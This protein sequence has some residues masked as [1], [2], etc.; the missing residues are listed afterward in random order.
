[1]G[2]PPLFCLDLLDWKRMRCTR[3]QPSGFQI[4]IQAVVPVIFRCRQARGLPPTPGV[5][6]QN[7][8]PAKTFFDLRKQ[9]VDGKLISDIHRNRQRIGSDFFGNLLRLRF[10][11]FSNDDLCSFA[12][13]QL[14]GGTSD[15]AAAAGN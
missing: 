5:P 4:Q 8:E 15:A 6:D 3:A 13:E 2:E 10:I 7:I 14:G 9:L 1:M 11:D 12:G